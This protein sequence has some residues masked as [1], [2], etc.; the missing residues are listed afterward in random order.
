MPVT[1]EKQGHIAFITIDRPERRNAFN[2]QM[3][4]EMRE[5]LVELEADPELRVA[6]LTGN[7][8]VFCAGMDLAAFTSGEGP[9]IV[10]GKGRFAGFVA[11]ERTKPVIAA[12]QGA[13]VAGGMEIMLACD[14][15]IAAE[16]SV[17]GVPE[18]KRG[19][20]AG[21][22][23]TFRLT[24]RVPHAIANE[25]LLTGDPISCDKALAHGL[26]NAVVP[27]DQLMTT[28]TEMAEKI[29]ANAPLA[30]R[31]SLQQSKQSLDG[32]EVAD[33]QLNDQLWPLIEN[34]EDA[35]EGATAFVE[36]R[37]PV[38]KGA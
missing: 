19:L 37:A 10:S 20:V 22:G 12:V 8:P 17:F 26:L 23:G 4:R 6:I 1:L 31:F 35:T 14:L 28:A 36:K 2:A 16:G 9:E 25:M 33:W 21:G 3:T 15:A 18:V 30:V 7:G 24:R 38:W 34:S 13:A 27:A 32:D 29:A 5:V 11:A